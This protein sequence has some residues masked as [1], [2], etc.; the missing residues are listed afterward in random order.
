MA[1]KRSGPR[2]FVEE[3]LVAGRSLDLAA[4][5]AHYVCNVMRRGVGDALLLFNGHDGEWRADIVT[6]GRVCTVRPTECTRPQTG[7]P[8]LW[9][10]FAP[11]KR[12]PV[13]LIARLATEL[14]VSALYPVVT[15]HTAVARVNVARLRANAVEAA[16][17]CGRLTVP[18]CRAP[19][20]L[21]DALADWP[22]ARRMLLCDESGG[23]APIAPALDMAA[24]V[25]TTFD[26]WAIVT[27]P[28]GGFGEDEI[29]AL[30]T[31]PGVVRVSLGP[32]ILRAETAALAAL[33]CWQ[34]RIGDWRDPA[35]AA[36]D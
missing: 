36:K 25:S 31:R 8:D 30:A 6:S 34:A 28:E 24:A 26:P 12:A 17:Q 14:G 18:E 19:V 11:V 2:L 10:L 33:A 20:P 5:Q 27:G 22:A 16:E 32:R 1:G 13:D 15:R 4:R 35:H 23:G 3:P 29:A 21:D 9:L 7:E